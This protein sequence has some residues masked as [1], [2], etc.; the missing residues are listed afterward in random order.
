MAMKELREQS[1]PPPPL[2]LPPPPLPLPPPPLPHPLPATAAM[3]TLAGSLLALAALVAA[4]DAQ[5][6][7][8]TKDIGRKTDHR[9][10]PEPHEIYHVITTIE[11]FLDPCESKMVGYTLKVCRKDPH[12]TLALFNGPPPGQF[13]PVE[14]FCFDIH[15]CVAYVTAYCES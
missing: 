9:M 10:F 12:G 4:A 13:F 7:C 6:Y 3:P 11:F 5:S 1:P 14:I 15:D 2:P 8:A